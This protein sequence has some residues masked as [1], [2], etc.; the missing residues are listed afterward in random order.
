MAKARICFLVGSVAM[1]GG[2]Y[3]IL[4]HASFLR[5]QGH[6]VTLAVQEPFGPDTAAWHDEGTKL[7][8]VTFDDARR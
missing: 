1:S 8:C 5:D 7:R 3:V 2:T 4:Q 6:E